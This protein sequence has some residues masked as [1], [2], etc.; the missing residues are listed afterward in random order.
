[1]V[2]NAGDVS[3]PNVEQVRINTACREK[4]PACFHNSM[5]PSGMTPWLS[6]TSLHHP[7][8]IKSHGLL[9]EMSP[10]H[11]RVAWSGQE[12]QWRVVIL[13]WKLA[14]ASWRARC[15]L[16]VFMF[17][18]AA[19]KCFFF[20]S[21]G[22]GA[23]KALLWIEYNRVLKLEGISINHWFQLSDYL[24]ADPSMGLSINIW[25]EGERRNQPRKKPSKL[26]ILII[27]K[28]ASR[29]AKFLRN[30]NK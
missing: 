22:T 14:S 2:L 25:G 17:L 20:S 23:S 12:S 8:M 16:H 19:S 6:P 4:V 24:R 27:L 28:Q 5:G 10:V 9:L 13:G 21:P 7:G 3:W 15:D 1:M 29:I 11:P 18:P 30:R 26:K